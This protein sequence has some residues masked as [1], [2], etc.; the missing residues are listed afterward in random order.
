MIRAALPKPSAV[1]AKTTRLTVPK[2][3]VCSACGLARNAAPDARSSVCGE[4]PAVRN[5]TKMTLYPLWGLRFH[6]PCWPTN[7]PLVKR[8][9]SRSSH[10]T[11]AVGLSV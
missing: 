10:S 1:S 7:I 3:S 4:R 5:G 2:A 11:S 9:G 8:S 6:E